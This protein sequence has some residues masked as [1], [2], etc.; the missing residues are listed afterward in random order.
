MLR[1]LREHATSWML[2]G[3]LILVAVTFIS[4]GGFYLI[5]EKRHTYAAKV[6]GVTIDV[7]EY[8]DTYQGLIKQ[9]RDAMGSSFSEKM[10]EDLHLKETVINQLIS[11]V[12]I[13]QEGERLGLQVRNEELREAIESIPSF[14]INGQ[15]DPR[16][17]ERFLRLNRMSAEDFE[18]MERD[19][20]LLSKVVNLV[21]LNSGKVSEEEVLESYLFE[22]E[23]TNL[24]FI[25]IIPDA[26]K[27]QINVNE[28]EI[29][30]YYH[31]HQEEFRIPT[32]I[33]I[34][35]LIFRP[36]D[37]EGK[38]HVS[39]E[40]I[41][42]YYD[43]HKERFRIPK[44]VKAR[45]ILIKVSPEDPPNKVEEKRK[46][47]EGI[48]EKAKK[49]KDF[50]SLAR[51][52]S[53][54][55]SASKGGDMGWVQRGKVDEWV[56][57]ALFS[58]KK[59]GELS[60]V[61][62]GVAGFYIFKAEEVV[63]EKQKSLDEVKDQIP[64][65][66][67]KEKAKAEAS[68]R[69][70]EAFYALF[71]SRDLERYAKEKGLPIKTTGFFKEGD[72]IPEMGQDPSF[73]SSA[74]SLKV[75]EISPVINISP[76]FYMLKMVDKKE[77]R[78][79]PLEE[80]KEEVRQK[81]IKMK[82]EDKARQ[83]AEDLLNQIR[84]G[85]AIKE[86]A[87]ERGFQ[88]EETGFFTRTGGVIPKIGPVGEY[89]GILSSLTEKNPSPKEVLRTK[90]GYFVVRLL[91]LEPADQKKFASV[92]KNLER[93]LIYQKQEESFQNWLNQL[94]SKAKIDINKEVL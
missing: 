50:G 85:K 23:R 13:L 27:G 11:K 44:R 87:K 19:R 72:V 33:R 38:V 39:Q 55:E 10:A 31:N 69:A 21:R 75:G 89:S 74:F 56:Q 25:K 71:R 14:Q 59:A 46:K 35:Y 4:W 42:R 36:S 64:Q 88:M 66:L 8:A 3:V 6:N 58:M 29:K 54:S 9:Y 22:N 40:D 62:R 20:L 24:A 52:Y 41:K 78:I 63:D 91:A 15:F 32:F 37:F 18:R 34:Q 12:L 49:T 51:Q 30:D 57:A 70:D 61:V 81:V 90:D 65:T 28:V 83:V 86:V 47:A 84:T 93:R 60:N 16:L 45:E 43:L 2:R 68:R 5:R 94:R 77:S 53:E 76:N 67:K 92:K 73:Y 79:P 26:F 17:Y 7:R 80:V 82:C 1:I 48:L